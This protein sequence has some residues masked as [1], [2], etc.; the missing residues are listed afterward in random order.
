[1]LVRIF[2]FNEPNSGRINKIR[3]T[4]VIDTDKVPAFAEKNPVAYARV[5]NIIDNILNLND[6]YG[7]YES[8]SFGYDIDAY[9]DIIVEAD[10]P[11]EYAYAV[12]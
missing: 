5:K 6:I 9:R 3:N 4:F 12:A 11:Y 10:A 2:E 8:H 1:M 7:V